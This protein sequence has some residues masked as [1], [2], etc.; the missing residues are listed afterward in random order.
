MKNLIL[1]ISCLFVLISCQKDD[2][3][4]RI[5]QNCITFNIS[6]DNLSNDT[7]SAMTG[8]TDDYNV[9]HQ[10]ILMP[11]EKKIITNYISE[12]VYLLIK[13]NGV[14]KE[15]TVFNDPTPCFTYEMI[16]Y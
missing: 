1:L 7:I 11:G 16:T 13:I 12:S 8:N 14:N 10:E 15:A 2:E 4:L 9:L 6:I 5:D 3:L